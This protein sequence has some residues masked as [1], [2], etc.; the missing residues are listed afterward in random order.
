MNEKI[1]KIGCTIAIY[2]IV[3]IAGCLCT[4]LISRFTGREN[5]ELS[6]AINA[7]EEINQRLRTSNT[8]LIDN[9]RRLTGRVTD[10][11]QQ[12]IED[13]KRYQ[14]RLSA[15]TGRIGEIAEG[16]AGTG[17]SLQGIIDGLGEIA[18]GVKTLKVLE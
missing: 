9:N 7:G 1:K 10:L 13:N 17:G 8:W 16:L 6:N 18:E 12:I 14:E 2:A 5:T 11:E 3:F 15:I 4:A